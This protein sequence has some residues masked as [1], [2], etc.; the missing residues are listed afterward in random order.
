MLQVLTGKIPYHY[1]VRESQ[2]LYAISKGIIPMRPNAPVVT[3]RQ[4]RFM[5]RCWMPV[6]VDEPRPRADEVV[7]F[8]RQELVEMRNSSL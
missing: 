6:D 3:D 4:W 8:A 5:Q 2:V 1:Y 7:E